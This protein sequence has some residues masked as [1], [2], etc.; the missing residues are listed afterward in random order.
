[1]AYLKAINFGAD[2][3]ALSK[4]KAAAIAAE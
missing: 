4:V 2:E 1:M 3:N